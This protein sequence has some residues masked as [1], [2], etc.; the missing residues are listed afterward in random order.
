M[1]SFKTFLLFA[2]AFIFTAAAHEVQA[3]CK[4]CE[5]L[6]EYHRTHPENNYENYEDY[7]KDMQAKKIEAEQKQ[8]DM[9]TE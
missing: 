1:I 3:V 6:R 2:F 7:L 8:N 9:I 5:D 4:K